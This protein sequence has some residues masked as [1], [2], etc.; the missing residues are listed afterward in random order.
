MFQSFVEL[1]KNAWKSL[2]KAVRP[3][4]GYEIWFSLIYATAL[5]PFAAWL[6]NSLLVTNGQIAVSNES[7]LF[8]FM[9]VR[10][11]LFI[12]FSTTFF[13]GLAFIEWIGLMTI[14]LA[15]A[16]GRVVSVSRVLGEGCV[17]AWSVIRLT[18]MQ[19]AIYISAGLP[20]LAAGA[21]TY[22]AFLAEHDINF[23]L[24]ARPWQF[25]IALLCVAILGG[26]YLLVGA[27]LY[28]RL[29]FALPAIIFENARPVEAL[30][31]SWRRTRHRFI[32]LA[33]PQA[34]WWLFILFASFVTALIFKTIFT[35]LLVHAGLNLFLILP[36]VVVALGVILL[37]QLFWFIMGKTVF[38]F[39]IVDFYRRTV[40]RKIGLPA[41]WWLLEKFSPAILQ[42]AGWVGVC[43]ALAATVLAGIAFFESFNLDRHQV[44]VT[45]HR[46]SSLK[47]PENTISALEQ[48]IAD[49]VDYAEID[50]QTTAD[51]VVVLM[52]D[53]DLM[54]IASDGRRI[55]DI[56]FEELDKLD[57]GRWFSADYRHERIA[58]LEHAIRFCK[59]RI[60][61][62]IELKY[63]QPD[64]DLA[65]KVGRLIR[66]H[67]CAQNCV[68]TSL[69]YGELKKFKA[70]FPEI[71]VGLI[72]FRALGDFTKSE[73][74]FFSIDAAQARSKLV[75]R[76]QQSGKQIHV[77][78]VNDLQTTL[79]MLEVGLDNIIT[80]KP[81]TIQNWLRAWNDLTDTQKI[82]LWMRNLFLQTT[83]KKIS[84]RLRAAFLQG[85]VI[86]GRNP[87]H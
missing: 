18:L 26:G 87:S 75:K 30:R 36:L 81:L 32:E 55:Q 2:R 59:G 80:D 68:V 58:T 70:M 29:L 56:P 79:T 16:D 31:R 51:G 25:W 42:K 14:C 35:F 78:T 34:V 66:K 11:V 52:H 7:I 4:V 28:I 23:Y 48:A 82:A 67:S 84:L 24:S 13:L 10:G 85:D 86:P 63:N 1:Y 38:M 3:V 50:V 49:G 45:A 65:E 39:L 20:F 77:W 8:F 64:P 69:D 54:R 12:L 27:W 44:A 57:V 15:A 40:K 73:A 53:A 41:K 6:V 22:L 21:L 17:Y 19:A 37:N 33:M 5:A 62:N 46:G 71:K 83:L 72:V 74:D 61:L 76:A 60:K 43:L 47:A 9:S